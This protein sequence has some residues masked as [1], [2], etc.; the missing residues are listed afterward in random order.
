MDKWSGEWAIRSG[1][2]RWITHSLAAFRPHQEGLVWSS[3]PPTGTDWRSEATNDR[4]RESKP[5]WQ[6]SQSY[7]H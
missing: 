5:L 4:S 3:P 1:T 7:G 2:H 6:S